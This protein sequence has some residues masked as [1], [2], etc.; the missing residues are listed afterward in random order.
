MTEAEFQEIVNNPAESRIAFQEQFD[1]IS[2]ISKSVAAFL[3]SAGGQIILG[4]GSQGKKLGIPQAEQVIE[5]LNIQLPQLV[6][7]SAMWSIEKVSYEDKRFVVIQIPE[8]KDKPYVV[9][10]GIYIRRGD[11]NAAANRDEITKLVKAR[12]AAG[13]RWERRFALGAEFSDLDFALVRE[14]AS[15]A[16]ESNRWDGDPEDEIAFLNAKGLIDSG[17]VKNAALLLFGRAPTRWFPQMR[18]RIISVPQGKT[19]DQYDFEKL[20]DSCLIK[21]AHEIPLVLESRVAGVS[22]RFVD[23]SWQRQEKIAYPPKALREGILNALI[24][25]DYES[26]AGILITV[27]D[28]IL[29]ITNPGSLPNG[30]NPDNLQIDHPSIPVNPDIAHICYLR[31]L[32]DNVGRGTQKLVEACHAY[33]LKTPKW[34]T[35]ELETTLTFFAP[36]KD[37]SPRQRELLQ[38]LS[39]TQSLSAPAL[40]SMLKQ[41]VTART[42]RSDL[43]ELVQ[44]GFARVS[45]KARN[46]SYSITTLGLELIRSS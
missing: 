3:N 20:F 24:H 35:S 41:E 29:R 22:A 14:T 13:E 25:R 27:Q 12:I 6:T 18:V 7:P 2:I 17:K 43:K 8:G 34:E 46:S 36:R 11:S 21:M 39:S 10:G 38:L 28:D 4:L 40:A 45:G 42:V 15:M 1:S 19:A 37:L 16:V 33:R 5:E 30:L 32:I 31:K 44:Q 9:E 26:N 23:E